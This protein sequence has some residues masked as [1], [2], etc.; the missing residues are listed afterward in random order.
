MTEHAATRRNVLAGATAVCAG[1]VASGAQPPEKSRHER[2]LSVL[3]RVA[4]GDA[5]HALRSIE[6]LAPDL[7]R[8]TVDFA[9]G[10][11]VSRTGLA[12]AD[13]E[14]C[15][16]AMLMA[17]GD[18]RPQLQFHMAGVLN[19]G[20]SP[21][22]LLELVILA[23]PILG[24]PAAI[25]GVSA[26]RALFSGRSITI[27]AANYAPDDR[28]TR[29]YEAA[30]ALHAEL[31]SSHPDLARWQLAFQFGE[32][33]ARE[34][35]P[36]RLSAL[37]CTAMLATGGRRQA[38][39]HQIRS[40]LRLG[41]TQAELVEVF[42]QAAVY[43]GFPA[44]INAVGALSEVLSQPQDSAPPIPDMRDPDTAAERRE[45]GLAVL[46]KTSAT[47]GEAVVRGL[48]DLAP[49]LGRLL[50]EHAYGDV[51]SRPGLDPK[52]RE[53]CAIAGLA[54]MGTA[55]AVGPLKV[56]IGA[57]FKAGATR[58][59]VEEALL[60]LEPFAGVAKTASALNVVSEAGDQP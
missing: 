10:D 18:A 34:K 17:L 3:A 54:A 7:A 59:E 26:V 47:A 5:T 21:E 41:V 60:N 55:T 22:H 58:G 37:S 15:T 53:L 49:D 29:G 51:F 6:K 16:V 38:L 12:L 48:D 13:R 25:D 20:G 32:V 27:R 56:H 35:L 24:F 14:L 2:G 57:A 39:M 19:A 44:A 8:M 43:A 1:G 45:R 28:L 50:I 4:G 30:T 36:H 46:V 52:T 11:V 33:L 9:F 40:A 23:A 42:T 31:S